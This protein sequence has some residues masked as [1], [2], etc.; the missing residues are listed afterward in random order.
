MNKTL[1]RLSYPLVI[2][3]DA[4]AGANMSKLFAINLG[5]CVMEAKG[6]GTKKSQ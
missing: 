1:Y 4:Q 5:R 2:L 3:I 6:E